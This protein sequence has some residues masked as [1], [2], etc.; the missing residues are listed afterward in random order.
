MAKTRA[1][2]KTASKIPAA[3]ENKILEVSLQHPDYGARR[4][5]QLLAKEDISIAESPGYRILKRNGMETRAKRTA[6]AEI[7]RKEK[8]PAASRKTPAKISTSIENRIV[9]VS[10]QNPDCGAQR[11]VVLLKDEDISVSKSSVYSI[12]K[13][14]NLQTRSKRIQ[15]IEESKKEPGPAPKKTPAKI[16][17]EVEE[18]I[19]AVS[20][21]NPDL[22]AK[23]LLPLLESEDIFIS[24]SAVYNILK[25]RNLGSR[26]KRLAALAEIEIAEPEV[27]PEPEAL[28]EPPEI[29]V[30]IPVDED[31]QEPEPVQIPLPVEEPIQEPE[32]TYFLPVPVEMIPPPK[33]L[34]RPVR[35][36][37]WLFALFNFLLICLILI[38]GVQAVQNMIRFRNPPPAAKLS[39]VP[40]PKPAA[41]VEPAVQAHV[42]RPLNDYR[43]IWERNLFNVSAKAEP[44]PPKEVPVEKIT[45][46]QKNLGLQLVGTVVAHKPKL[47]IA[48]IN[49]RKARDQMAYHEGDQAG[50][51]RI[52]KILRNQ[53]I[54]TTD[55]GDKLL[56]MEAEEFGKG[57]T[58]G[59]SRKPTSRSST[60]Q[61]TISANRQ[62]TSQTRSIEVDR[63][64]VESSLSDMD[65]LMQQMRISP[66]VLKGEPSGFR[67]S[68]L[69]AK[70]ILRRMGLLSGDVIMKVNDEEITSPEQA[71]DFL[72]K[73]AEGGEVAITVK[74]RRRT[75]QIQLNIE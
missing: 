67:I 8:P 38:L 21:Q 55:K 33:P 4:L 37:H 43:M 9:E 63:S 20:L 69:P 3:V 58:A 18:R 5:V 32:E 57:K 2:K 13:R 70:S 19:V 28:Q 16:S 73:L 72:G 68:R 66:Y 26:T 12:L 24:A 7:Q 41:D 14:H 40:A 53:V 17:R 23:R 42:S 48:I 49:D 44:E 64:E 56:T 61:Q 47:S 62:P 30:V 71:E 27:Q 60:S 52:K 29:P 50:K 34:K 39:P 31:E 35:R 11:L 36:F 54:I 46:A 22:G 51:V 65:G 15:K 10:L 74:R 45:L 1:P 59:V 25:R 6:I 75:R